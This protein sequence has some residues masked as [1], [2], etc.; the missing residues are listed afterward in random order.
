MAC[1]RFLRNLD[2][3]FF[4]SN[5]LSSHTPLPFIF[6]K[7]LNN[8]KNSMVSFF[9]QSKNQKT[10]EEEKI[11]KGLEIPKNPMNSAEENPLLH[12]DRIKKSEIEKQILLK[13][14]REP[15][16]SAELIETSYKKRLTSE[17]L[18]MFYKLLQI[19]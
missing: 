1:S 8:F 7:I 18:I 14:R 3:T 13:R 16:I 17:K 12:F 6:Q 5:L 10:L 9:S 15:N 19:L 11:E 2:G 4:I